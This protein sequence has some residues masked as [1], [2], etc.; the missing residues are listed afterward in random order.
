MHLKDHKGLCDIYDI[1]RACY[2]KLVSS[3]NFFFFFFFLGFRNVRDV[4]FAVVISVIED[5]YKF[6]YE[7]SKE[8]HVNGEYG[9]VI[10]N[11]Y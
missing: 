5:T 10:C 9:I 7:V 11:L 2:R 8:L 1:T 3:A 6:E 4:E